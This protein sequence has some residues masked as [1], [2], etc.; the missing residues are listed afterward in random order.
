MIP[1]WKV[2]DRVL[3]ANNGLRATIED[4]DPHTGDYLVEWDAVDMEDTWESE[5]E[6]EEIRANS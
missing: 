6:L 2:G 4:W 5:I 1:K 3:G